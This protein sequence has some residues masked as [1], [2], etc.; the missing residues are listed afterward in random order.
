[1]DA[2]D[3]G[4]DH[5]GP[6]TDEYAGGAQSQGK[7]HTTHI[8]FQAAMRVET[9]I[10][11]NNDDRTR[12]ARPALLRVRMMAVTRPAMMVP[13]PSPRAKT[14]RGRL[15]LQMVHRMKLG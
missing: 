6:E 2:G 1:M 14:T 3:G 8:P 13:T 10:K 5:A 4:G 7:E 11:N 15:P 12:Q 9:P